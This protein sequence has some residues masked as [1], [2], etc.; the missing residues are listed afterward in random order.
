MPKQFPEE[1]SSGVESDWRTFGS[2]AIPTG[3]L[4]LGDYSFIPSEKDC[5]TLGVESGNYSLL[6]KLMSYGEDQRISRLRIQRETVVAMLTPAE[7]LGETWTDTARTGVCDA[8]RYQEAF[9]RLRVADNWDEYMGDAEDAPLGEGM[10]ELDPTTNAVMIFMPS[11][12]GDGSYP[13]HALRVDDRLV[14]VEV[15]FISAD[16][17]YPFPSR[18]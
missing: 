10:V 16:A 11:G 1:R 14:G 12:F 4:M 5:L 6:V 7:E 2:I 8:E 13:V 15:E 9:N 17:P 3:K 18:K